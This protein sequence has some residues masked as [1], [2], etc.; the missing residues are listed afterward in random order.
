MLRKK[1]IYGIL[2]GVLTIVSNKSDA[3][4]KNVAKD[5]AAKKVVQTDTVKSIHADDK[6]SNNKP[7]NEIQPV[8]IL[9]NVLMYDFFTTFT[10]SKYEHG[11]TNDEKNQLYFYYNISINDA[12]ITRFFIWR[13]YV[14]NEY[15]IKYYMDSI[16]TKSDDRYMI[17]NMLQFPLVKKL[18]L[19]VSANIQSQLWKT[20]NYRK[21]TKTGT[22]DRYLYTDY[23]SPG[24]IIYAFGVSYNFYKFATVDIGLVGGRITKIKNQD[25]FADRKV[26]TLYGVSEG[27]HKKVEYGLNLNVNAPPVAINKNVGWEL[28]TTVFAPKDSLGSV[29]GWTL[30]LN[31]AFHFIFLSHLR[32][33]WR[34]QLAYDSRIQ[35]DVFIANQFSIGFYINNRL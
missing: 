23:F 15:G 31:N 17:R 5:T 22:M 25:I 4:D 26:K 9:T 33:T 18:K 2:I 19:N 16:N 32:F 20:Y 30:S 35:K 7:S 28:N 27:E 29:K 1:Q 14:F 21:D 34:T 8:P 13:L 10:A 3:Q 6:A 12:F 11:E 24:Y